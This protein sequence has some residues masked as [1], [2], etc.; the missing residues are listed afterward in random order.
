MKA[1][2]DGAVTI[3]GQFARHPVYLYGNS[4]WV[5]EGFNAKNGNAGVIY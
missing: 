2:N 5:F 1:L 3:D 4:W